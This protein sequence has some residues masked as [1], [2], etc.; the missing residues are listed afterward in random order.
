MDNHKQQEYD[1]A[2]RALKHAYIRRLYN[3]VRIID[4]ILVLEKIVPLSR[5]DL[6]RAQALVHGLAGSGATFG[7]PEVTD[8]GRLADHFLEEFLNNNT[9]AV[10]MSDA[11]HQ[12]FIDLLLKAQVVCQAVYDRGRI[13]FP[14]LANANDALTAT[15]RAHILLVEDDVEI[16]SIM[17]VAIETAGMSV[18]IAASGT[19]AL[20]YLGRVRPDL[21]LL[22]MNLTDMNGMEVLQQIKQN[23]EF[24]DIPV[25]I[26]ATRYSE[27]DEAF[28]LK[29]GA[30]AYIRKPVDIGA[31]VDHVKMIVHNNAP[32][33]QSI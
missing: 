31:L 26:L 6:V 33:A 4:N 2:F 13:E 10:S 17:G 25:I 1:R 5:N 23:S 7:F 11:Q 20:H 12:E 28:S 15:Q 22:D 14:E 29:A 3:T 8:V 32:S 18:Q 16:S 30:A 9:S 27:G 21:V 24:M 19:D